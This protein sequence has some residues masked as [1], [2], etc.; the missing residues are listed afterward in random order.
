MN[1]KKSILFVVPDYHTTFSYAK[2]LEQM[3]W[4]CDIYVPPDYPEQLLF[5]RQ[6]VVRFN[7]LP[8]T[9][10]RNRVIRNIIQEFFWFLRN[11]WKYK[12]H[13]YYGRLPKF[14]FFEYYFIRTFHL[15]IHFNFSLTLSKILGSRIVYIPTGCH[16]EELKSKF[17]LIG[18][19]SVCSS[20]GYEDRCSDIENAKNFSFVRRYSNLNIGLG[21]LDPSEYFA[22][23]IKWKSVDPEVFSPHLEIP[24]EH[25]LVNRNNLRVY[26]GFVPSGRNHLGRDIKGTN[27]INLAIEKLA[28]EGFNIE[29]VNISNLDSNRVRFVQ[30]QCD[31]IV[32]QL[33]YG[34]WGSTGVEG[35]SLGKP[36]VCYLR[37]EWKE[38]FYSFF[39]E[40]ATLPIIEA[41]KDNIY[42]VLKTLC[43][44]EQMLRD[45]SEK[46]IEFA[47]GHFS[48]SENAREFMSRLENL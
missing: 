46:S 45:A 13:V 47:K 41:N 21:Y 5:S 11:F 30:G 26:F 2:A 34:W 6:N 40:Y 14:H 20:C 29:A 10:S 36:V 9:A 16:D 3:G 23:T 31:V 4:R 43:L 27:F 37:P 28:S 25:L 38:K 19:Q 33:I 17:S 18:E 44:N 22:T 48:I 39:P 12:Y 1:R 7:K 8:S 32:D 15:K 42:E 35:M 24:T